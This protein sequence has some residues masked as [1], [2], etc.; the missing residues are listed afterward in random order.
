MLDGEANTFHTGERYNSWSPRFTVQRTV[1]VRVEERHS[2]CMHEIRPASVLHSAII[3]SVPDTVH[4]TTSYT[5]MY[6]MYIEYTGTTIRAIAATTGRTVPYLIPA[7]LCK[8]LGERGN[9]L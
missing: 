7:V 6:R 4:N 3:S 1:Q 2:A 9:I 5:S 8:L